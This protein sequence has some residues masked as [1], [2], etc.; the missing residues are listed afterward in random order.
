MTSVSK[1]RGATSRDFPGMLAKQTNQ[2]VRKY[3]FNYKNS[4]INAFFPTGK[5]VF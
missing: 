4:N 1:P 3:G 5:C 2:T